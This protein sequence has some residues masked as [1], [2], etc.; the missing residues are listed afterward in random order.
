V[1]QLEHWI[2]VQLFERGARGVT[3]TTTGL[4]YAA[5]IRD[6]FDRLMMTSAAARSHRA[7]PIV[8]IRALHGL[9]AMWLVARVV[10]FTKDNPEID[11]RLVSDTIDLNP[12]KSGSDISIYHRRPDVEGFEQT[13]FMQT[14][15]SLYAA[16]KL[17]ANRRDLSCAELLRFPLIHN[18]YE[19]RDW[20]YPT[21]EDWFKANHFQPPPILPGLRFAR[22]EFTSSACVMG[23][24]LA[25]LND[26]FNESLVEQGALIR[27]PGPVIASPHPYYTLVK[28]SA[29]DEVK[30]VHKYLLSQCAK[31]RKTVTKDNAL[32]ATPLAHRQ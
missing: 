10:A 29:A 17:I 1:K 11:L 7:R 20:Q 23:A 8:T 22:G 21:L 3:L 19:N 13:E 14:T 26:A 24:G 9:A 25:L 15:F 32:G 12:A 31:W 6:A 5:R 16:P 30:T 28:T 18:S 2:G 4:E 27:L